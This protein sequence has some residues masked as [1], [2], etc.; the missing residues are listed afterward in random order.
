MK[1]LLM[2]RIVMNLS[3][4]AMLL[5]AACTC[6]HSDDARKGDI[7]SAAA[8][9]GLDFT[10]DEIDSLTGDLEDYRRNYIDIR[11]FPISNDV[12]PS[13][14]VVQSTTSWL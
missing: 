11:S 5:V 6:Q 14:I 7:S 3:V 8:I 4:I 12:P 2:S 9:A 13:L 10:N 1:K